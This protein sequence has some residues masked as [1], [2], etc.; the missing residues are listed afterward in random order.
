LSFVYY[1]ILTR[2]KAVMIDRNSWHNYFG[3]AFNPDILL[4]FLEFYT[5]YRFLAKSC[6][7]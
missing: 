5:F 3:N 2:E 1:I 7:L 6:P 4:R